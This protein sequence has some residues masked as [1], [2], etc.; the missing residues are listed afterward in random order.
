MV[1]KL[2]TPITLF[3]LFLGLLAVAS[4]QKP[5]IAK[6]NCQSQC[7]DVKIPYPF[8]IGAGC[9]IND[10]WFQIICDNSSSS[11]N[12]FLSR[13]KQEVLEISVEGRNTLKV[14]TP[15][16]FSNCSN[17]PIN[18]QTVNLEGSPF[19][20]SIDNVFTVVGCDVTANITSN[21][22]GH[23]IS[24]GSDVFGTFMEVNATTMSSDTPRPYCQSYNDTV[25]RLECTCGGGYEGNPYLLNGCQDINECVLNKTCSR[26]KSSEIRGLVTYFNFSMEE[27]RLFDILDARVKQEGVTDDILSV[28]NLANRCLYMSGNRRPTMKEVAMELERIQKSVKA[29]YNLQQN[30]NEVEYRRK[31]VTCPWILLRD[32]QG[33]VWMEVLIHRKIHYRY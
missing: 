25:F 22:D 8:G 12:P 2:L 6:L 33:R 17:M 9:N 3:T 13:T 27:N 31:E 15:I 30:Y 5:P 19:A 20:Y 29:S 32:Q 14:T 4:S 28:A 16:A 10:D 11:P 7:G 24:S 18:C 26:N 1:A 21:S 23:S